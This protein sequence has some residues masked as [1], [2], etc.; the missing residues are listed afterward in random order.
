MVFPLHYPKLECPPKGQN[1]SLLCSEGR[2]THPPNRHPA[3]E[4]RTFHFQG[5]NSEL[6]LRSRKRDRRIT[7]PAAPSV[8]AWAAV[9]VS[10]QTSERWWKSCAHW[11]GSG[12]T[13]AP[14]LLPGASSELRWV[15]QA[16]RQPLV[17]ASAAAESGQPS[18]WDHW[19]PAEV[20]G[21]SS[22]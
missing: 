5:F 10:I 15:L 3:S 2:A 13:A 9:P 21:Y 17:G 8:Y 16:A 22:C 11:D 20:S 6:C 4:A 14:L 12:C 1:P 7:G 18:L 19:E